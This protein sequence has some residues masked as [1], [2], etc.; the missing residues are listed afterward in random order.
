MTKAMD[1]LFEDGGP[2]PPRIRGTV[3]KLLSNREDSLTNGDKGCE[4][5][6]VGRDLEDVLWRR[7]CSF[8]NGK[9]DDVDWDFLYNGHWSDDLREVVV[10]YYDDSDEIQ[11][12]WKDLTYWCKDGRILINVAEAEEEG[13]IEK[14]LEERGISELS[15]EQYG[16]EDTKGKTTEEDEEEEV[17]KGEGQISFGKSQY[18]K[19]FETGVVSSDGQ[20]VESKFRGLFMAYL[21]DVDEIRG[22][23]EE[24]NKEAVKWGFLH[25]GKDKFDME[26][27][28]LLC[29]YLHKDP[30]GHTAEYVSDHKEEARELIEEKYRGNQAMEV[31]NPGTDD[32]VEDF[33]DREVPGWD[34]EDEEDDQEEFEDKWERFEQKAKER[35][36]ERDDP[37]ERERDPRDLNDWVEKTGASDEENLHKSFDGRDDDHGR[38]YEIEW[39]NVERM[40]DMESNQ[41]FEGNTYEWA[42][43]F[44]KNAVDVIVTSPPYWGLRD[45]DDDIDTQVSGDFTCDHKTDGDVCKDCGAFL[46]PLGNEPNPAMFVDHIVDLMNRYKEVL[47]PTGSLWLNIGDTYAGEDIEGRVSGRKKS[48]LHI[49]QRVYSRMVDEGWVL[50]DK[51][52]W[53]KKVWMDDDSQKGNGKPFSGSSRLAGQWEPIYRFTPREESHMDIDGNRLMPPSYDGDMGKAVQDGKFRDDIDA[54]AGSEDTRRGR[55][56]N[57]MGSNPSDVWLINTDGFEG[58]HR[59][60]FPEE[61]PARCA[62][63]TCPEK[64]CSNCG[65]P[66]E[67]TVHVENENTVTPGG[68]YATYQDQCNCNADEEPGIVFDP[69]MGSGTTGLAASNEGFRW[70]GT[71]LSEKYAGIARDRIPDTRTTGLSQWV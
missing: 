65:K 14:L 4:S 37:P 58:D 71:E 44:P 25:W 32:L 8:I 20:V 22:E 42:M 41:I 59:A 6:E 1:I 51:V 46:G 69:F 66:Y 29:K 31:G 53:A 21:R 16:G 9:C 2:H 35:A 64:V 70:A 38:E 49:P 33:L 47:K 56:Y 28:K 3:E 27:I 39:A 23:D 43:K 11:E 12:R 60:V 26:W 62:R 13:G 10:G 24:P 18:P 63:L 40:D 57:P 68:D 55:A 67:K 48:A 52:I 7:W 36:E 61:L 34:E 54:Q 19:L 5:A 30:L 50:R 15:R 45:Y 17:D